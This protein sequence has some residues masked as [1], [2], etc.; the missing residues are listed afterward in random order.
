MKIR[1]LFIALIF[2]LPLIITNGYSH[3]VTCGIGSCPVGG[4][5]IFPQSDNQI[6]IFLSGIQGFLLI[7]LTFGVVGFGVFVLFWNKV[8][9]IIRKN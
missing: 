7:G 1:L 5:P 2:L 9:R 8:S 4:F 3:S 6:L